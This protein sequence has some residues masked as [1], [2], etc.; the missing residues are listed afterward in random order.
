M[1]LADHKTDRRGASQRAVC[2][3]Q[4]PPGRLI[5]PDCS[6]I[7]QAHLIHG[8]APRGFGCPRQQIPKRVIWIA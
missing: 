3:G 2:R 7:C 8:R 6:I 5:K 4:G 1:G